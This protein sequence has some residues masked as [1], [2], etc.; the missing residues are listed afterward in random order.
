MKKAFFLLTSSFLMGAAAFAGDKEYKAPVA[1]TP[2]DDSWRFSL[3]LPAW[4]PWMAGETGLNGVI[5][6]I[7]LGPGDIIRHIDMAADV[8]AEAHKGRFSVMGEFLYMSL[9]DGIGT[10]TVAKKLDVR[11]D[12]TMADLGFAWRIIESKRGWLDVIG[13]VRYM[14]YYQRLTVQPNDEKID[15]LS[16]RVV[17]S[18]AEQAKSIV[19]DALKGLDL[20][21]P[22]LPIA[23]IGGKL[24]G[25]VS[26][27]I[28]AIVDAKKAELAAAVKAGAAAKVA[29]IK[30]Q[31]QDQI[32]RTLHSKLDT[33]VSRT[34]YWFDPYIGLR[35]RY[36]LNEKFY[37]LGKGDVGGFGVGSDLT[38]S[39]EVAIG[40]HLFRNAYSEIG[41]RVFGLDFE[42]D[43]L[44]MDTITHG[45]QL[46]VRIE[47]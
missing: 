35:G 23:P 26:D 32:A 43:G 17:N 18:A 24:D 33:V 34:D 41:Y 8:R 42:K 19:A 44:L 29:A 39:A 6:H 20:S 31:L 28:Q 47:F 1:P 27:R 13:G 30:A 7:D 15:A 10:N 12:Q 2:L 3:S 4:I 36:D 16:T 21:R 37:L 9:S 38:W 22:T 5:S 14:N 11:L 40:W 25:P 46:N 45:P